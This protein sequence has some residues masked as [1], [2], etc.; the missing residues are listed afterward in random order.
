MIQ[1][2]TT[3][4]SGVKIS[5]PN[6]RCTAMK[7]DLKHSLHEANQKDSNLENLTGLLLAHN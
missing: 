6:N 4:G 2:N 7:C 5:A 3:Q 1:D